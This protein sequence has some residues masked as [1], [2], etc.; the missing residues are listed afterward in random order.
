LLLFLNS[1]IQRQ[2][3][4]GEKALAH[5]DEILPKIKDLTAWK[6]YRGFLNNSSRVL[7]FIRNFSAPNSSNTFGFEK[8]GFGV[9]RV[10]GTD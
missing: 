10:L 7:L 8:M 5:L 4:N 1:V 6:V 9:G 2:T 3:G